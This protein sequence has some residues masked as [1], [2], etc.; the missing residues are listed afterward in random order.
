M[1][2]QN[3][4]IADWLQ[5]QEFKSQPGWDRAMSAQHLQEHLS[6]CG[7]NVARKDTI[8]NIVNQKDALLATNKALVESLEAA[9]KAIIVAAADNGSA[10]AY[11]YVGV[12][13]QI[14]AALKMA[15]GE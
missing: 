1:S 7:F 12:L 15:K 11:S 10:L 4:A 3:Q 5:K 9:Q 2:E 14:D 8:K 6:D 13:E